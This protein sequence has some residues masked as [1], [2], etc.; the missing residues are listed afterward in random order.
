MFGALDYS[1]NSLEC[2]TYRKKVLVNQRKNLIRA[3]QPLKNYV[4]LIR[5]DEDMGNSNPGPMTQFCKMVS[6]QSE[7]NAPSII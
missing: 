4:I 5:G 7:S 3:M 6:E 2:K 1:L